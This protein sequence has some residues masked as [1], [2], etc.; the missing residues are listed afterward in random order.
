MST[1]AG[2]GGVVDTPAP[3]NERF[4]NFGDVEH[5]ERARRPPSGCRCGFLRCAEATPT[6][7]HRCR[8]SRRATI[9]W[10]TTRTPSLP[11]SVSNFATPCRFSPSPSHSTSPGSARHTCRRACTTKRPRDDPVG[12]VTAGGIIYSFSVAVKYTYGP[13]VWGPSIRSARRLK[14]GGFR[15]AH[16]G[17]LAAR[18]GVFDHDRDGNRLFNRERI[19]RACS[20]R[21]C[22]RRS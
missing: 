2:L 5:L 17:D 15:P 7:R 10:T 9:F 6:S 12:T 14:F 8:C 19:P 13:S 1:K 11:V 21:P 16:C 18:G 22:R 4:V 20:C 3:G